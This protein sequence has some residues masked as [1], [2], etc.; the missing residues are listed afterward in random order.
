M[1]LAGVWLATA[2]IEARE[3]QAFPC[4]ETAPTGALLLRPLASTGEPSPGLIVAEPATGDVRAEL[5][6]PLIDALFPT[7]LPGLVLAVSGAELYLFDSIA[8]T[9]IKID[10]GGKSAQDLTPNEVQFRGSAGTRYML[11]GSPSFDQVWLVD[12]TLGAAADLTASVPLPA[13]GASVFLSF[14]AIT[15]DD[16]HVVL[17]DGRHVYV[18]E[19]AAPDTARLVDDGAFAF[20]PDF[21]PD[22]AELIYSQSEGPGSG[23]T[24][25]IEAMEG[26]DKRVLRTSELAMVTLWVPASRTIFI[27]ERTESGAA[28]GIVSLLDVDT[29]E[30]RAVLDYSGSLT[31]VQLEPTGQSALLGIESMSN[32]VWRLADL[33]TAEVQQL[34]QLASGRAI[35]GL[36]ADTR[37]ALIVPSPT[38]SDPLSGPVY[39]AVDLET[40]AVARLHEQ[41]ADT[42]YDRQPA[43]SP[44]SNRAL[45]FGSV[46]G[47]AQVWLL[48]ASE[49]KVWQVG[50]GETVDAYFSP[51]GC[52]IAVEVGEVGRTLVAVTRLDQTPF[53]TLNDVDLMA[54]IAE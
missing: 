32:G 29:G 13:P 39:R 31:S 22:G 51:D 45:V 43:L 3:L 36:F 18:V 19:T 12:L 10:L 9:A 44:D 25:V 21:S 54:W 15:P 23:S 38:S 47:G 1:V 35:P 6:T 2:G 34:P 42:V 26:S 20:A 5:E 41:R 8:L 16:K 4:G 40:G 46:A 7:P 37:W 17:W 11:L 14:A 33:T 48:D 28:A 30:E 53:G 24:L 50:S 27:D 52:A 49:L